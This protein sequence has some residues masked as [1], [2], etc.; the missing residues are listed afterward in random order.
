MT[1][2]TQ[3][4]WLIGLRATKIRQRNIDLGFM[5]GVRITYL[6]KTCTYYGS[7]V[8]V[9]FKDDNMQKNQQTDK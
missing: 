4:A 7:K 8:Q 2:V 1:N 9:K 3:L 6:T 5:S